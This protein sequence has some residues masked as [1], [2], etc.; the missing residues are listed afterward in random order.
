MGMDVVEEEASMC[1]LLQ[2]AKQYQSLTPGERALLRLIEGLVCAALVAAPL[3]VADAL[4]SATINW[5]D[6]GRAALAAA[7]VAVLLALAKYARAHGDPELGEA[8]G[9]I[10]N[11]IG[12]KTGMPQANLP[13]AVADGRSAAG[14]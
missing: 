6:V 3:V 4:G 12:E 8:L 2:R 13:E 14:L 7:C 1:D 9:E 10:G 5:A 11:A